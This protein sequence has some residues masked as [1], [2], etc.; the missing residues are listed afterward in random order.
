MS[1][2]HKPYYGNFYSQW[3]HERFGRGVE[4]ID[5]ETFQRYVYFGMFDPV[6]PNMLKAEVE[7]INSQHMTA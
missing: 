6:S 5:E 1:I 7:R 3:I 4:P 2:I